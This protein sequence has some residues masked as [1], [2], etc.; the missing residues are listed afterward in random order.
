[1]QPPPIIFAIRQSDFV[2]AIV[3]ITNCAEIQ[4]FVGK[5]P[6]DHYETL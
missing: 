6:N 1:M 3:Q 4:K 5:I 2:E